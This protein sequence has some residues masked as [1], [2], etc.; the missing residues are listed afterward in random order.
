MDTEYFDDGDTMPFDPARARRLLPARMALH[1][2]ARRARHYSHRRGSPQRDAIRGD[3]HGLLAEISEAIDVGV[4]RASIARI[5]TRGLGHDY[6]TTEEVL[7]RELRKIDAVLRSVVK[8]PGGGD[9]ERLE[10]Q[11]LAKPRPESTS[12]AAT[13]IP[14]FAPPKTVPSEAQPMVDRVVKSNPLPN[15]RFPSI[16]K[17]K[18]IP[19]PTLNPERVEEL[20][21]DGGIRDYLR[22]SKDGFTEADIGWLDNYQSDG[23]SPLGEFRVKCFWIVRRKLEAEQDDIF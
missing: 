22:H 9:R 17:K 20:D 11:P 5:L 10:V 3:I 8:L 6:Q 1:E 7:K 19:P 15:D 14:I 18:T 2:A 4:D 21:P 12:L 23:K 13:A 16:E